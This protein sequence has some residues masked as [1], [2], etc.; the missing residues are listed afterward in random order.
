MSL[1]CIASGDPFPTVSWMMDNTMNQKQ[2]L[3]FDLSKTEAE[4]KRVRFCKFKLL[5]YSWIYKMKKK[6]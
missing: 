6:K 4:R 2:L 3:T 5:K 1:D